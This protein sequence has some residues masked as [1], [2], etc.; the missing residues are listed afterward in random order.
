MMWH[1]TLADIRDKT[2]AEF[3][4]PSKRAIT[5]AKRQMK[6]AR[7]VIKLSVDMMDMSAYE[8]DDDSVQYLFNKEKFFRDIGTIRLNELAKLYGVYERK[9]NKATRIKRMSAFLFC[10]KS[11]FLLV[12]RL[13]CI[14]FVMDSDCISVGFVI[15][16]YRH[17]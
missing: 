16:I 14:V 17:T 9:E 10:C 1:T 5:L 7:K 8:G 6:S 15:I 11:S 3:N 13:L 4:R 2:V 12:F